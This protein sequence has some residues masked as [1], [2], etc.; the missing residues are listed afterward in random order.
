MAYTN[1]WT[2]AAPLDTQAANQGAVDFR[3]TK[4]DV[5]QR[6]SSFGAGVL[7]N[8]PTPEA[9]SG[10]AD[11]TG[12]MYW[13]TDTRQTFRW[14]GASW[15]DISPSIS[16]NSHFSD[17]TQGNVL[18]PSGVVAVNTVTVPGSFNTGSVARITVNGEVGPTAGSPGVKMTIAGVDCFSENFS[19]GTSSDFLYDL[20]LQAISPTIFNVRGIYYRDTGAST[21]PFILNL[22]GFSYVAGT[23]FNVVLSVSNAYTG[24]LF[25]FGMAATIN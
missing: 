24:I 2:T 9:T 1:V 16:T 13:A 5:M 17:A 25:T 19:L 20:I 11:W 22:N 8:R 10:T 7:A 14:N 23:P 4:L 3:A 21:T 18:N 12:V 6:I 15:D